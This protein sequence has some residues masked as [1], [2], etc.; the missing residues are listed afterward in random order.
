MLE[1]WTNAARSN[2]AAS[3]AWL[4]IVLSLIVTFANTDVKIT[5]HTPHTSESERKLNG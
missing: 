1:E 4:A 3:V 5:L 2:W